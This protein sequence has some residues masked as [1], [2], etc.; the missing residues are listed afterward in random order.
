MRICSAVVLSYFD[1]GFEPRC[2][3]KNF[4]TAC[5]CYCCCCLLKR[6]AQPW[7]LKGGVKPR[8]VKRSSVTYSL[9]GQSMTIGLICNPRCKRDA[10]QVR[11]GLDIIPRPQGPASQFKTGTICR[12]V[13]HFTSGSRSSSVSSWPLAREVFGTVLDYWFRFE[14]QERGRVPLHGVVW[15]QPDSISDDVICATMPRESDGYDLEFTSYLRSLYKECNMVNQCYPDKCFNIGQG[16]VCTKCKSG[17]PFTVP[18]HKQQL[19]STGVRVLY[20]RQEQEEA[21]VV[22]HNRR[23]LVRLQCHN[24]VQ[25]IT[26]LGWELYLAKYLTKAAKSLTV[27]MNLSPNATD[28]E[29]LL[30]LRSLGRMENGRMLLGIHQCR[31]SREVVWIPTDPWP[32]LRRLKRRKHLL[33]DDASTMFGT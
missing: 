2:G 24:N 6:V 3:H 30:K 1:A 12:H 18:Q 31:G 25:R 8:R 28:V 29:R 20:R 26:S 4:W 19:D 7:T 5:C 15:C 27:P 17:Y 32:K 14:Y 23:L 13:S 21:C 9:L 33:E 16:R 11:C 10:A 22:P